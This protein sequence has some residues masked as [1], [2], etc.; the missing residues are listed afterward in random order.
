MARRWM[1]GVLVWFS[2]SCCVVFHLFGQ[3]CEKYPLI[4]NGNGWFW[5]IAKLWKIS[6]KAI[7]E[8]FLRAFLIRAET[9]EGIAKAISRSVI[10]FAREPWPRVSADAKDLVR[11]MLDPNPSSRFTAQEVLGIYIFVSSNEH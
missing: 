3:V 9:D 5:F 11:H 8:D 6:T 2:T 7:N 4:S 10:D 1:C